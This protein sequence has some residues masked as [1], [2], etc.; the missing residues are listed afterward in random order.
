MLPLAVLAATAAAA[1]GTV[2]L[3]GTA[4]EFNNTKV[5]L[6]GAQI[7]VAEDP[8][9]GATVK[10]DGTYDLKV[11][12]G[13]RIT[14]YINAAGHHTIY[15]Q[16]F[17]TTKGDNLEHV[18]FQTPSDAIYSALATL[19]QVP[20][21]ADGNPQQCAVVSTFSTRNVR[22]LDYQHFTGYGA[23][24]VAG[25]TA[26]ASP[27][28]P[29]PIYFNKD[30]IP[31]RTQV[32]SSPDGGVIWP[33]VPSGTYTFTAK[34]PATR[35]APFTA[36]CAPGR[37]VNANPPWGLHELGLPN[38]TTYT[39][40]WNGTHAKTFM[41]AK[42]PKGS[43]ITLTYGGT[44]KTIAARTTKPAF[45]LRPRLPRTLKA[46]RA[47]TIDI[48]ANAYDGIRLT[49]RLRSHRAPTVTTTAL[50]LGGSA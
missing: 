42:V 45:D 13:R 48:T 10:P 38:P 29:A 46:G 37:I 2:H 22:A 8:T 7:R 11:P 32:K 36:T 27:A 35:F 5:V 16:T 15:L 17:T 6:G 34:A 25:A 31:D 39:S 12:A 4:Y 44:T 19:L 47:L 24:G 49:L 14:P 1:S 23:H 9:L 30:V 18:N 28:L 43:K 41:L 33:V 50:P 26:S 20:L 21:G 3:T 40:G